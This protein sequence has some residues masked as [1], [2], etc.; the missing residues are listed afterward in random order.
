M[1]CQRSLF[2]LGLTGVGAE[3]AGI[4]HMLPLL[5]QQ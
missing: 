1:G 5:E 2:A 3:V 4:A